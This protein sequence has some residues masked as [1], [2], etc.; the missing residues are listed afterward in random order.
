MEVAEAA[1]NIG[2][3]QFTF[4]Q[5]QRSAVLGDDEVDL[6]AVGIA[7]IAQIDVPSGRVLLKMHP[8]QQ[9]HRD[10]VFRKP[11]LSSGT[12]AQLKW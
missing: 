5:P 10:Q 12:T 2:V 11:A 6:A 3:A 9:V 8:F 7:K 1:M 4:D